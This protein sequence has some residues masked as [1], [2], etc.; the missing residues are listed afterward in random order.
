MGDGRVLENMHVGVVDGVIKELSEK[1]LKLDYPE[2]YDFSAK[3]VMPGLID[4]H[5]HIRYDPNGDPEQ[6]SDEYQTLRGAENARKA[7]HS[8]VTSLG[9]AGAVR[10]VGFAVR[11]AINNGLITGPRLYVSGEMITI[12]GGRSKVPGERL[13]VNGADSAREAARSLL[14]YHNADFIK[15]ITLTSSSWEPLAPLV[16]LILVLGILSSLLMR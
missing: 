1:P 14:M 6:R 8:G 9:E 16:A 7:L 3:T 15:L 5:V 4:A 13:E 10:N 11:E 2:S 12:T